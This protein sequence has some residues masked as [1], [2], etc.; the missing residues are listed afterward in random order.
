MKN[1]TADFTNHL[2]EQEKALLANDFYIYECT[3]CDCTFGVSQAFEDHSELACP[4]C[5]DESHVIDK[6]S[7]T[8]LIKDE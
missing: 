8:M 3:N 1:G 4:F 2:E 6:A 5:L 7:G